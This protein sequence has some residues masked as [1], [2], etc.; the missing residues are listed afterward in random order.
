MHAIRRIK[1]IVATTSVNCIVSTILKPVVVLYEQLVGA[2]TITVIIVS[3]YRPMEKRAYPR[4]FESSDVV[5]FLPRGEQ[6]IHTTG[7]H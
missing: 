4:V 1:P 6:S 5:A 2:P 7:M 3:L